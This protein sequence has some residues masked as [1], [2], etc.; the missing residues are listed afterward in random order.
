MLGSF[1]NL[2]VMKRKKIVILPKLNDAGG[3]LSKKETRERLLWLIFPEINPNFP[4][5]F[6]S[7]KNFMP[8]RLPEQN[9]CIGHKK[10]CSNPFL[11]IR[12]ET[13]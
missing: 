8:L 1:E 12:K 4:P 9:G 6:N 7:D 13:G 11:S 3:D 2:N 5:F 10:I